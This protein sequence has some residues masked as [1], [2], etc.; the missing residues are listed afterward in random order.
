VH[1]ALS[2]CD[3]ILHLL[4]IFEDEEFVYLTLEYQA[5]GSL[6]NEILKER[7]LT[8]ENVKIIME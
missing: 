3:G 5:E 7:K 1:W 8:E 6:L 4:E 2:D